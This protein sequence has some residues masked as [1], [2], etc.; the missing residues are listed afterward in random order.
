LQSLSHKNI[1]KEI[2]AKYNATFNDADGS[3]K[4]VCYI[5]LELCENGD[6]TRVVKKGGVSERIVRKWAKQI[7]DALGYLHGRN[8]AHRDVKLQNILLDENN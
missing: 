3:K 1:C 8:I 6:L 4:Q 7:I 5:V 2:E